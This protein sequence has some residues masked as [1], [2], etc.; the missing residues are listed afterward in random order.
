MS[1]ATPQPADPMA[2]M[3]VKL[4]SLRLSV[5]CLTQEGNLYRDE[6]TTLRSLQQKTIG[7]YDPSLT[8]VHN[9]SL[10]FTLNDN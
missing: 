6:I 7:S 8:P 1:H 2:E 4:Q 9:T 3:A 5:D 10:E